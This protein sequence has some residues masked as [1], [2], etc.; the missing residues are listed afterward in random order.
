MPLLMAGLLAFGL[1]LHAAEVEGPAPAEIVLGMSTVLSGPSAMLGRD[2]RTG[3]LA[4]FERA[5]RAGG[6]NGRKLRLIALD[7]GYEP[8][9][10]APN[11]RQLIEQD[12]V[13]AII[14][15]VGTPTAIVA[16]P[17]AIE[18]KTLFFGACSGAGVLR[19]QPADRYVI[20]YR[21]SYAEELGAMVDGLLDG[22]GL[23]PE[24]IAFFTQRDGYGDAGF[25][26]GIQALK[27]RGL[28]DEKAVLHVR[29]DRNTLAV[30][31]AVASLVLARTPPRAIVMV[32][33]YAPSGRFIRQCLD[34]GLRPLFI[35]VSFVG[36]VPLA[37]DLGRTDATV[38]VM[39]VVPSPIDSGLGIVRDYAADL[40]ALDTSLVPGF[41]D[42]EGYISARIFIAAL[43]KIKGEPTREGIVDALE[44][45][46]RFD[47]GVGA[48][49]GL[50]AEEHQACHRI[51]PTILRDGAFVPFQWAVLAK[52]A[53]RNIQP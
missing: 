14:G 47:L 30:E 45:L 33:A 27:R 9:R 36:G 17:I 41:G 26:S 4:G 50:G 18:Q 11:M 32:G 21:A 10:T 19:N 52:P 8:S 44:G 16:V 38:V 13:L 12:R 24:E 40:R 46:G 15:N 5:N 34:A 39:Q 31:N 20:N 49:L 53:G 43:E 7:D 3:V 51:W 42:L 48:P 35:G 37:Q 2:M 22:A 25:Y 1:S 28:T 29:Y 6:V 23:K